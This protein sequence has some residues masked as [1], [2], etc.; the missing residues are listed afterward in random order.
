MGYEIIGFFAD[1]N[2]NLLNYFYKSLVYKCFTK[3]N[4]FFKDVFL[5][6]MDKSLIV[7][8]VKKIIKNIELKDIGLFILLVALFNTLAMVFMGK[9]IDV[10]SISARAFFFLLS[11]FL[12]LRKKG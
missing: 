3:I 12:I 5:K 1:F 8:S 6:N 4:A 2:K 10:F 11:V 9:E 7:L